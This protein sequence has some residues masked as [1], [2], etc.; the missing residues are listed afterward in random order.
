MNDSTRTSPL[1]GPGLSRRGF[2][3]AMLAAGVPPLI[4]PSRV[5]GAE[6]PSRI[7]RIGCIGTGRMGNGNMRNAINQGR[8]HAARIAAVCDVD[9]VRAA[10]AREDALA[11]GRELFGDSQGE[12]TVHQDYQELLAREDID[13]VIISAPDFWHAF[14][15]ID[16]A[17][18]GKAIYVEKPL[19]FTVRE[20][21][22]LV[23]A[24]RKHGVVLQTG[25]QQRSSIHF[26]RVCWLVRNGRI[27]TIREVEVFN[28]IDSG[29]GRP[30]PMPVPENLDYL[31]WMGPTTDEPYTEDRVHPQ[32]RKHLRE[33]PGWLQIGKYCHG[34]ITGWGAHMYDIAQWG[35]GTD[36]DSGP[37]EIKAEAEF[38]DRGLF[39][40]HTRYSGE[41]RYANGVLLRSGTGPVGMVRFH[42]SDGWLEVERGKFN[43][44]NPDLLREKP[45]GGIELATS[46]N[47]MGNFLECARNGRE[48][49]APVEVGH[50]TNTV[51]MLHHIAMKTGRTLRWDPATEQILDDLAAAAMLDREYREGFAA[52]L[53]V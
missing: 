51:C 15:A 35:L 22:T 6:A 30:D 9:S 42:G 44:S 1:S 31:R 47:H 29:S 10:Q 20:G 5:L 24:V 23:K 19:T 25:S 48:P 18:T 8:K 17:R 45:V 7:L 11:M 28:P 2:L 43:A 13:A 12:I 38:P 33:R 49:V 40:V 16:A 41:A 52:R 32:G 50:R 46:K 36:V 53:D 27:G 3:A 34:M 37:V 39:D 4:V 26:H 14:M 21:Q